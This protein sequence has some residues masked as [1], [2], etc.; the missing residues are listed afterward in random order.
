MTTATAPAN[1][2]GLSKEPFPAGDY[3]ISGNGMNRLPAGAHVAYVA[4]VPQ[5]GGR[6]SRQQLGLWVHPAPS[7][8]LPICM[9]G[10]RQLIE[11]WIIEKEK[12]R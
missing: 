2:A 12:N 1:A 9:T 4:P 6:K 3:L 8:G 5:H 10:P 7:S 11:S